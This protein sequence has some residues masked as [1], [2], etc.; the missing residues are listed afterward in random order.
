MP[1]LLDSGADV[2]MVP[3]AIAD[4]LG[5]DASAGKQYELVGFDG[6]ATFA[7]IV[8]LEPLFGGRKFR[9]QFLLIDQDWGI[10]G[11]NVLNAMPLLFDGP[12][13]VWQEYYP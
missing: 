1:F 9:G 6:T 4:E 10:M 11:R 2:T 5:V 7:P 3:R 8:R 13:L 12:R